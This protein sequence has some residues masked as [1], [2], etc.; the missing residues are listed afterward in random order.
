VP[1]DPPAILEFAGV[2]IDD[3]AHEYDAGLKDVSFA[4]QAGELA[5]V[6]L[7]RPR[8]RTPIADA[9][10]GLIEPDAGRVMFNGRDWQHTLATRASVQRFSIGRVFEGQS[11]ISNLDI[12]ENILLPSAHHTRRPERELR[13]EAEKLSRHFGLAEGLPTIR[14]AKATADQ[15]RRAACVRA[16]MGEPRL[17]ILERPAQTVHFSNHGPLAASV[18][19][20]R[21]RGAAVLWLTSLAEVF[22]D[23]DLSPSRRFRMELERMVLVE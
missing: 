2:T 7:E 8:F 11:W 17:L 16:F 5:L 12:D 21:K 23:A 19:A 20:A 22:E 13:E 15:L 3:E 6:M 18:N 4:L 9:A 14:P 10:G 1:D